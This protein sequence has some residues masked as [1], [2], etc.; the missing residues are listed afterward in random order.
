MTDHIRILHVPRPSRISGYLAA[1]LGPPV[2]APPSLRDVLDRYRL[3]PVGAPRNL[4]LGR[5]S[6][7][8]TV[9]T[10]DGKKVV[11][12]Y[13]P[14]WSPATV[15]FTHSVLGRLQ[16]LAFPAPRLRR[17]PDGATWTALA[18]GIFAVFDFVPG[19]NFSL[20]FLLRGDRLRLTVIAGRTLARLHERLEGFMPD[21]EHHL[22]FK[23][24]KGVRR[25]DGAW[26]AAVLD[27]LRNRSAELTERD[28]ATHAR[29]LI[30]RADYLLGAIDRLDG[31][32]S[33]RSLPRLVIHGDYGLH[34]LIFQPTG[35]AVPVDFE[36]CRLDWR[37]NDLISALS[38][39]RYGDGIYDVES[40][41]TFIG[42]YAE[43]FPLTSDER[44][45]LPDAWRLYKLQAA[46]RYWISYFDTGGPIRKLESAL[47]SI[48]QADW[49]ADHPEVIGRLGQ[50]ARES[51]LVAP[52]HAKQSAC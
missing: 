50:A 13:R 28:A 25:E 45:L 16:E 33:G 24:P 12:L 43:E 6:R 8:V 46:V 22:G 17:T 30:D 35:R 52:Q 2:I 39:Y 32:L 40:M 3:E 37:V 26:H 14:Q 34:N 27:D 20:N 29:H 38:K 15:R 36:L 7:N 11:K 21:G 4:R 42:A 47:D 18:D 49:V 41:E 31:E 1:R 23:S 5:R 9:A 44:R 10:K 51:A 19:K 48:H